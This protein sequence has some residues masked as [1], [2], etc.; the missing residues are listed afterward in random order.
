M[1]AVIFSQTSAKLNCTCVLTSSVIQYK[2]T[3][4]HHCHWPKVLV[5]H[6]QIKFHNTNTTLSSWA[7]VPRVA[8]WPTACR[9]TQTGRSYWLRRALRRRLH[10][11]FPCLQRTC[12][13]PPQT[14]TTLQRGRMEPVWV[15]IRIIMGSVDLFV[16]LNDIHPL[17]S[18]SHGRAPLRISPG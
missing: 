14:G 15:N 16:D 11:A 12:K 9:R 7:L 6:F 2:V 10:T 13:P 18:H 4:F 1:C 3:V 17:S 8:S 5:M